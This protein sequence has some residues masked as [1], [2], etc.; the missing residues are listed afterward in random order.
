[1]CVFVCLLLFW[2]VFGLLFVVVVFF[3]FVFFPGRRES[4]NHFFT[5]STTHTDHE[6]FDN[7]IASI[8]MCRPRKIYP[9]NTFTKK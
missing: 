5:M 1:M 7:I 3:F 6:E 9:A 8:V 4:L 2:F